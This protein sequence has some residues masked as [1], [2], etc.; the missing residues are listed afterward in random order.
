[1][2]LTTLGTL[3]L[4]IEG[5]ASLTNTDLT[6]AQRELLAM[7]V[8]SPQH[9]L[10]QERIQ[11]AFWPDSPESTLRS[12]L[13]NLLLRFRQVLTQAFAPFP[14]KHYLVVEKGVVRLQ[15]CRIDTDTLARSIKK[16][17]KHRRHREEWQADNE[18]YRAH[19]LYQGEFM[20]GVRLSDPFSGFR[21]SLLQTYLEGIEAWIP[22][23]E[24]NGRGQEAI[25]AA[26]KAL[27]QDPINE[28]ITRSLYDLLARSGQMA[29]A[30]QA[31]LRYQNALCQSGFAQ[32]EID[33]IME[34]FWN[35]PRP[36]FN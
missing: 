11:S 18:F 15:N 29:K 7:L 36:P 20:A 6:A 5:K 2:N 32:A 19:V 31:I 21:E 14:A 17:L 16:G 22:I 34:A 23:L 35:P 27:R 33:E 1:M 26:E 25:G 9:S 28:P 3:E 24:K 10:T 12:K 30:R 8:A 4:G 13:D